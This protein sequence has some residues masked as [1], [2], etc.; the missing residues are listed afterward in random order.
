MPRMDGPLLIGFDGSD[1][2]VAAVR[3]AAPLLATRSA[4]VATVWEQALN[5][6]L[7]WSSSLPGGTM[8][9]PD[10]ADLLDN[11]ERT[12]ATQVADAGV[13]LL[14]SLGF[15]AQAEVATDTGNVA[16]T[17]VRLAQQH[18]ASAILIGSRGH[19]A[20]KRL[21][22]GSTGEGLLRHAGCPVIVVPVA[23]A[24]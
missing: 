12:R 16:A 24:E 9:D 10:T 14:E 11:A 23:Q 7:A 5:D 8:L 17:L 22:L 1:G 4:I 15:S 13:A 21:F 19:G 2:A 18:D 3:A 20:L 6:P